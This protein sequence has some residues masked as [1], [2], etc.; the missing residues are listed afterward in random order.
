MIMMEMR[1]YDYLTYGAND[2][3]GQPQLSQEPQGTVKLAIYTTAQSTQ[4]NILYKDASY[5]GLTS[6]AGIDDKYVI[7]Y[8]NE[9][10]KVLYIQP[11]GRWKQ[12][13]LSRM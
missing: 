4:D 3:Y 9:R 13:F 1:N 10:L 6:D 11:K 8:G 2:E 12:V 5:I 7:L